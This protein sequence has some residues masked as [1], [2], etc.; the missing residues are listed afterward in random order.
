M[1]TQGDLQAMTDA[2]RP[3]PNAPRS[4]PIARTVQPSGTPTPAV[5]TMPLQSPL[6]S[7]EAIRQVSD[8]IV[9][10][11]RPERVILFGSY[12]YGRPGPDSDVDLLVVLS[13]E[14]RNAAKTAE[15][16]GA[17]HAGFPLDIVVRSPEEMQRRIAQEDFFL[18]EITERG[19][20]LYEADHPGMG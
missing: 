8:R 1:K 6:I 10:R 4:A 3:T 14:G 16:L 5:R 20:V 12:A 15:I 7:E 18:R 9:T 17:V 13:Y 2:R 19:R 11:F